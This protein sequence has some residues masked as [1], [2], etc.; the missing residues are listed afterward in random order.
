MILRD[1]F[2]HQWFCNGQPDPP[3]M[4]PMIA[5]EPL[6]NLTW[7]QL[8][9]S[10]LSPEAFVFSWRTFY[11]IKP[12]DLLN[13]TPYYTYRSVSPNI[14][15]FNSLIQK[16]SDIIS[17]SSAIHSFHCFLEGDNVHVRNSDLLMHSLNL[18]TLS[19]FPDKYTLPPGKKKSE[20]PQLHKYDE[21]NEKLQLFSI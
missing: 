7:T 3:C 19:L 21:N 14:V 15:F 10:F 4:F 13:A 16:L 11:Y 1:S 17:F 12:L 18:E 20:A 8:N 2:Q 5:G 9:N 6:F